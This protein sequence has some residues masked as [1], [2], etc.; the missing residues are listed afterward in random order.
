MHTLR[1]THHS[2][3][4]VSKE[5]RLNMK[6]TKEQILEKYK[7]KPEF[8]EKF[9]SLYSLKF[10]LGR[11][12]IDDKY[13]LNSSLNDAIQLTKSGQEL[14]DKIFKK[15]ISTDKPQNIK[16]SILLLF[17]HLDLYIDVDN[18]DLKEIER[19]IDI[20]VK[21]Q[22]IKFPWI[23]GRTLYD[24]YFHEFDNQSNDLTEAET[25]KLLKDTPQGVFQ[26]GKYIIGPWGLLKTENQRHLVPTRNIRLYHC[27]DSSCSTFHRTYLATYPLLK[28]IQEEL[29]KLLPKN[30]PS[31]WSRVFGKTIEKENEYF[32][33]DSLH[34]VNLLVVNSFGKNELKLILENIITTIKS[35]REKLP[36]HKSLKGSSNKIVEKLSK[37]E[38]FQL[39]LLEED[40]TIVEQIEKL[41]QEE[42]LVIP[43][44]EIRETKFKT[45]F[46]FYNTSHQC[47]KLGIRSISTNNLA[48][49]RL[50]RLIQSVNDEESS[51]QNL[52]WKLRFYE[53][54]TLKEKIE[55]YTLVTEP[56]KIIKETILSGPLQIKKAF[57][58]LYGYFD[59]PQDEES[60]SVL[61]DKVL[62]KLGFDINIY[63]EII[64]DFWA[65]LEN[66]KEIVRS[67]KT[68]NTYEKD[69]IRSSS[70]NL[71]VA[72]EDVLEQ[73]LSF[74]T[75]L[76]L[77]DHYLETK[78]KYDYETAR[79]FMCEKLE[80]QTV[81]SNDPLKFD[82]SG[83]N[84][85]FPLTEGFSA[86]I[87]ICDEIISNRD[88]KYTRSE[89]ELPSYYNKANF[90][91]FPFLHKVL[92]LDLKNSDYK[93]ISQNIS[94]I[95][96]TFNKHQVLSVRNRLQ[97]KRDDFPNTD[98]IL[99]SCHAIEEIVTKLEINSLWP[100]VYLFTNFTLDKYNR[101]SNSF[102][103]YKGR[104]I[105]VNPTS[106]FIGSNLISSRVPQI[107]LPGVHIGNSLEVL[108]IQYQEP[109]EYL[110]YWKGYPLKKH[111]EEKEIKESDE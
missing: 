59:L 109:S 29:E 87:Q 39:L 82:K 70:V 1:D 51:K 43:A 24:K 44:T 78:F 41:I 75:W 56:T 95:S 57:E 111:E 4:V 12:I 68:L 40:K 105:T 86:L 74:V 101:P 28:A 6:L 102:E 18:T 65:K 15:N 100:N 98:E 19:I 17:Y 10:I 32:D 36:K 106:E 50:N 88:E 83:K 63:P 5:N 61:I 79:H 34:E 103:D 52:E 80:G 67:V 27:S 31:E 42:S 13:E 45:R 84:T 23:Y 69:Q 22:K 60:E 8:L 64:I 26:V 47:N 2:Q 66:F 25:I 7:S 55:A 85:L 93:L 35:F 108:R 11:C 110:K 62:W 72:L 107:I 9:S 96:S 3:I 16:V 99:Q 81:G 97:H 21:S 104:K 37:A 20:D 58:I 92:L 91:S 77:S 73:S 94:N 30:E 33:L 89:S 14:F 76:L 46:G 90:S 71:F 53:N 54:E 48:I 38:L 49:N